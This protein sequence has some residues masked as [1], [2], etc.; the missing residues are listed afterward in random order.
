M[1]AVAEGGLGFEEFCGGLVGAKR[2]SY[3]GAGFYFG[4][5]EELADVRG[6]NGIDADG[7]EAEGSSFLA[8]AGDV[9]AGGF[10]LEDGVVD[11]RGNASRGVWRVRSGGCHLATGLSGEGSARVRTPTSRR[12]R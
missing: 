8:E 3:Y 7:S 6:E 10:G 11:K 1:S 4:A 5:A 2:K 9:V 12:L